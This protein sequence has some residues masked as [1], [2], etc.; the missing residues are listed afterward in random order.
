MWKSP[1]SCSSQRPTGIPA[2]ST[3]SGTSPRWEL[4]SADRTT[5]GMWLQTF[6]RARTS[7]PKRRQSTRVARLR[8]QLGELWP[9]AAEPVVCLDPLLG[10]DRRSKRELATEHCRR[11]DLGELA[12]LPGPVAA[13]QFQALALGGQ[14]RAAAVGRDDQRRE[15]DR[16]VVVAVSEQLAEAEGRRGLRDIGRVL[17][18]GDCPGP[19]SPDILVNKAIMPRLR[20]RA[21]RGVLVLRWVCGSRGAPVATHGC[22]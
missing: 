21:Q 14:A 17:A 20:E 7:G 1:P 11:D 5:Y 3:S 22:K 19:G 16:A 13:K 15:R 8:R 10:D 6:W 4:T 9:V 12:H 2:W 18:G